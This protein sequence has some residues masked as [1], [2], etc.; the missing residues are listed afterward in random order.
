MGNAILQYLTVFILAVF[1]GIEVISKVPA[2]L[3]TPLMS[4]S[5][6]IHGVIIVGS[7]IVL[8][9]ADGTLEVALG[10]AAVFLA[11]LNVVG[12]FTVTDRML[13]MFKPKAAPKNDKVSS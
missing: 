4:G 8:G 7:M 1:I 11:T 3:H 13:G 5:N 2:I 10:T 9:E 6:A 12:G